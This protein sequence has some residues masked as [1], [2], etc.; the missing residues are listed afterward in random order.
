MAEYRKALEIWETLG[1]KREVQRILRKIKKE[2]AKK[3]QL[4]LFRSL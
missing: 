4:D 1:N 2:A 3:D